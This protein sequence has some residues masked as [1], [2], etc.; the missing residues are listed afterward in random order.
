MTE[1][2]AYLTLAE[3]EALARD[4][5]MAH[6]C[7]A[8]NA[9]AIAANLARA[10][11]DGAASHGLF[12]LAPYIRHLTEG[13]ADGRAEMAPERIAPGVVRVDAK[14]GFAPLAQAVGL[15]ALADAAREQGVAALSILSAVHIAALW[16]E[17]SALAEQG[18]VAIAVTSSPAYV[19]PA[20]GTKPF[21]GTNPMAFAW[22]REGGKPPMVWDQ[23]SSVCARGEVML[24]MRQGHD[25]P[26]GAGIDRDGRPTRDPKAILEG[27]QLPFGGYKGASIAL[28]V[29]LLA[30]PLLGQPA[31]H[32]FDPPFAGAI[33]PGGEFILAIDPDRFGA[34]AWRAHGERLFAALTADG[35]ARLPGNR[36]AATRAKTAREGIP[37]AKAKLAEYRALAQTA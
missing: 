30:G 7:D 34:E 12:R 21:F 37:I 11:G 8:A 3:V 31:S 27:A 20:G 13:L 14:G 23:A 25:A 2:T 17:T 9:A 4:A 18:L 15:P 35:D 16:P 33:P 5:L 10:E 26:E 28:M 29:D 24:A 36:R 19:A 6:G 32:E 22:P 1:E